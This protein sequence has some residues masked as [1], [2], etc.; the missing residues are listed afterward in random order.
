MIL[1]VARSIKSPMIGKLVN[2]ELGG[3]WNGV[4]VT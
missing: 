2:N 1:S 3:L 4:V